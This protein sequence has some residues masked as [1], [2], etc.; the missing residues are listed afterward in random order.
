MR[1]GGAEVTQELGPGS[2]GSLKA[3]P[4]LFLM[5][6]CP[7]CPKS[8]PGWKRFRVRTEAAA[9]RLAK[10]NNIFVPVISS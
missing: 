8:V 5:T 4:P 9:C 7:P 10:G 1:L 6:A 2:P 3:W